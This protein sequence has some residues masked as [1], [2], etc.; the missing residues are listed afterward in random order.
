MLKRRI[1]ACL[2]V[3]NGL[4][5]QSISFK[6]YL[7]VGKS[8]ISVEFLNRW[9]IDEIVL[10]DIDATSENR[11]PDFDSITDLSG[12]GFVP[13]TVGG[14]IKDLD[15]MRRLIHC[16]ADKILINKLALLKPSI[17]RDA[18]EI[19]GNQCIVV[20]FDVKVNK[21]GEYE[22]FSDSGRIPTGL[23]PVQWAKEV[24]RLGAGEILLNSIDRDGSK[25]GYD[26]DLI[27]MVCDAVTIPVIA[28]GGA[29]HPRH[30]LEVLL[31]TNASA[32]AAA[33]FFH[34]FE[35]PPII[36]KSYLRKNG[37]DVR[38]DSYADYSDI[39]FDFLGRAAKRIDQYLEKL[40]FEYIPEEII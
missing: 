22:L 24:E 31:K 12:K 8:A 7:P 13:L 40:R 36:V 28:C 5:V 18:S 20:S 38:L 26:L 23:N 10:L 34:F 19:F 11:K 27:R 37:V 29:D 33:N 21:N 2:V 39:E 17:I 15:D 30:F 16:G 3:K 6:K 14:G 35:H 25:R 1:V 32:V 4:V 9:G